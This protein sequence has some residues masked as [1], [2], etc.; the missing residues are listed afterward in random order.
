[1]ELLHMVPPL[2][3]KEDTHLRIE[4]QLVTQFEGLPYCNK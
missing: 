4:T 2:N 3:Q 1:V